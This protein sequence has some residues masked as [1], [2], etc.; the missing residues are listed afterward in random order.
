VQNS[1]TRYATVSDVTC[2]YSYEA[3]LAVGGLA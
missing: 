1:V 3:E 2:L